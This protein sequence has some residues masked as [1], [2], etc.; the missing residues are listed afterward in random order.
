MDYASYARL[1]LNLVWNNREWDIGAVFYK[2][3]KFN[4][5]IEKKV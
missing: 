1:Y 3:Q 5:E 2:N 4:F